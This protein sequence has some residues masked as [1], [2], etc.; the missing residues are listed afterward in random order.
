MDGLRALPAPRSALGPDEHRANLAATEELILAKLKE[1]GYEVREEAIKWPIQERKW[2]TPGTEAKPA[3]E[4]KPAAEPVVLETRNLVVDITGSTHPTEVLV[5][6]AHFDCFEG[7]GGADDNGT[8]TAALLE[9][10]RTLKDSAPERTIRLVFFTLEENGLIGSRHH[11]ALWKSTRATEE[12][13]VGMISLEMLGYYTDAEGSQK[14]PIPAIKGIFEPPTVGNFIAVTG[15]K[16]HQAFSGKLGR[17]MDD[18]QDKVPVMMADIFPIA[19]PDLLRSDHAPFLLEGI[20]AVMITDTANF[21]NGNYHKASDT[22]ET[23]DA[24][25]FGA[26]VVALD[27]AIRELS[28]HE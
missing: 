1:L 7:S 8:G 13:L 16:K 3:E 18:A 10:A 5:V 26:V 21:R 4:A 12:K 9:L 6:G 11:V 27:K 24:A 23:I 22:V 2:R 25:R 17:V 15:I 14:S 20:P 28:K 19:P